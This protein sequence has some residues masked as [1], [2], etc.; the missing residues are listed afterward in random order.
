MPDEDTDLRAA[1]DRIEALFEQ[2][3]ATA[4]PECSTWPR[5]SCAW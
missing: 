4:E 3:R 2:L 1:G 5:S